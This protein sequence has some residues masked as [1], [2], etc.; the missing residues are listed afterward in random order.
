MTPQVRFELEQLLSALCDGSLSDPEH[1]RLEAMLSADAECRRHYLEYTDL[2]AQ[3]LAAPGLPVGDLA[4]TPPPNVSPSSPRLRRIAPY[5][6]LVA[7]TLII[8]LLLQ[9]LWSQRSGSS[10]PNGSDA[11][12]STFATLTQ[13]VDCTWEGPGKAWKAGARVGQEQIRLVN[14]GLVRV[15]FDSGAELLVEGPAVLQVDGA[16]EATLRSG[17]AFF[18]ADDTGPPFE[19]HTP[20]ATLVDVGTEYGVFVS[21]EN[22]EVHVFDGE[23]RRTPRDGGEPERLAAGEARRFDSAVAAGEPVTLDEPKFVRQMPSA[24]ERPD[25]DAGLI[26]Y[27]GFDYDDA[28]ALTKGW[29]DRG[30]GWAG[31]W[32]AAPPPM[33]PKPGQ[34][35]P[36]PRSPSLNTHQGLI[37][38]G[39]VGAG[40]CFDY[41]GV[42]TFSRRLATPFR[43]DQ[44]GTY[45]FSFLFRRDRPKDQYEMNSLAVSLKAAPEGRFDPQ[46]YNRRISFSVGCDLCA[47]QHGAQSRVA[48]PLGYGKTYLLVAKIVAHATQKNEV[49]VRV[50]GSDEPVEREETMLWTVTGV[51]VRSDMTLSWVEIH[52]NGRRRQQIDEL[53]LGTT[54]ASVTAP[55]A[56]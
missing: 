18:R 9:V 56:K 17:K 16:A 4:A 52:V 32:I 1:V 7:A 5:L 13:T 10:H 44:D 21:T 33:F 55:W 42:A 40:G 20:R 45:Y 29:A 47:T 28:D 15:R 25:S 22:E 41:T 46:W 6:A 31:S 39:E 34:K 36:P 50:Y 2:H 35:A 49:Y 38:P 19:L 37:H 24:A 11:L 53:R 27:E 43:L 23:V 30:R 54:W 3:L 48:L 8:S 14:K 26:A 12:P 51:P